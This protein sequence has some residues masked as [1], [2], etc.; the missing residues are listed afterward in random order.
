LTEEKNKLQAY[1][2]PYYAE[3][4]KKKKKKKT[5][6][7]ISIGPLKFSQTYQNPITHLI[8]NS[9]KIIF[10]LKKKIRPPNPAISLAI[11]VFLHTYTQAY[12]TPYVHIKVHSHL[13]LGTLVLSPLTPY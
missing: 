2:Q 9:H 5:F 4:W 3:H 7:S 12:S 10:Y 13:V 1:T 11:T 6:S 8:L